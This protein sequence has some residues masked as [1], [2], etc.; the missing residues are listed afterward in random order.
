MKWKKPPKEKIAALVKNGS[1]S[2]SSLKKRKSVLKGI[3][4]FLGDNGYPSI[5][6]FIIKFQNDPNDVEQFQEILQEFFYGMEKENGERPK[7]NTFSS[8]LTNI[9]NHVLKETGKKVD[10]MDPIK[11]A[12]FT[13]SEIHSFLQKMVTIKL[14]LLFVLLF[15][16]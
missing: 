13:V 9:K 15:F 5:E 1:L 4:T 11:F 10:I 12:N 6:E 2:A 7:F 8:Y 3:N 14:T 16:M